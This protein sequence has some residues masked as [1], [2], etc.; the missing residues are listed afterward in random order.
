MNNTIVFAVR[1]RIE[2]IMAM[3]ISFRVIVTSQRDCNEQKGFRKMAGMG[4]DWCSFKIATVSC[5]VAKKS[6]TQSTLRTREGR[7][8]KHRTSTNCTNLTG[9]APRTFREW[10]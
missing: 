5:L 10:A 4:R 3:K 9:L 8:E 6:L 1:D 7:K 2:S